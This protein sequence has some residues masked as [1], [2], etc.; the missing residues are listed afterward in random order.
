MI[1]DFHRDPT[2][3]TSH[4]P[5]WVMTHLR[6]GQETFRKEIESAGWVH[7]AEPEIPTLA[8]NYVMVFRPMTGREW[9]E[10]PGGGWSS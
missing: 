1:V 4:P 5:E 10:R 2:K 7:V 9:G 6:A 3:V 8:E